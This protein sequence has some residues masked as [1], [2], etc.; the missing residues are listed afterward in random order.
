MHVHLI[1]ILTLLLLHA[2][3]A[4]MLVI[5]VLLLTYQLHVRSVRP[6]FKDI[7]STTLVFAKMG[8]LMMVFNL[9]A[10]HVLMLTQ[11]V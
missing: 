9:N 11:T 8:T 10:K 7:S 3:P 1:T 2:L 6:D 5:T 4:T